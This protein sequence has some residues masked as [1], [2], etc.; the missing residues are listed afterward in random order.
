M[1]IPYHV[2]GGRDGFHVRLIDE[3]LLYFLANLS[4]QLLL[5]GLLKTYFLYYFV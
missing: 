3:N 4:D 5:Y 2:D 1:N